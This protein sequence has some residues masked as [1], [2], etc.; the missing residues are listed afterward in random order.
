MLP[1]SGYSVINAALNMDV[2]ISVRVPA[3]MRPYYCR[4]LGGPLQGLCQEPQFSV[5]Q[6]PD[7]Y[8]AYGPLAIL[9]PVQL[10]AFAVTVPLHL[11]CPAVPSP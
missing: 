11:A 7:P 2:Q 9:L 10:H 3:F 1:S 4:Y 6:E 8:P 5:I